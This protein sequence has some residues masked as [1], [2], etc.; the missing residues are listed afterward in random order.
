MGNIYG[1]DRRGDEIKDVLETL[2]EIEHVETRLLDLVVRS[3]QER[4]G[5]VVIPIYTYMCKE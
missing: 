1:Q 2:L 4:G 3:Y 5:W